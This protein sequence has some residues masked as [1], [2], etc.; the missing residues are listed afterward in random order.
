MVVRYRTSSSFFS[1]L[2]NTLPDGF[3]RMLLTK[4]APDT[5]RVSA[6]SDSEMPRMSKWEEIAAYNRRLPGEL[7]EVLDAINECPLFTAADFFVDNGRIYIDPLIDYG[8]D[9]PWDLQYS[10]VHSELMPRWPIEKALDD[11]A[12]AP[13]TPIEELVKN[14]NCLHILKLSQKLARAWKR[15]DE[16]ERARQAHLATEESRDSQDYVFSEEDEDEEGEAGDYGLSDEPE[17][18]DRQGGPE[19]EDAGEDDDVGEEGLQLHPSAE[20]RA[21]LE[22]EPEEDLKYR[23]RYEN[24][25]RVM[26]VRL[27][28]S[29]MPRKETDA[30][31]RYS[32]I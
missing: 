28:R 12:R 24:G 17:E 21:S 15:V 13:R 30:R 4:I 3:S 18:D 20:D 11:L 32:R 8:K 19:E 26:R 16:E 31:A 10:F 9:E 23:E 7:Q 5:F 1:Q 22:D 14:K 27:V 2:A 29:R 25:V 6:V